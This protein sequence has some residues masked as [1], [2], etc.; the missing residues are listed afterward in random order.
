MIHMRHLSL[1]IGGLTLLLAGC[2]TDLSKTVDQTDAQVYKVI[3]NQW[4]DGVGPK[5]N[6]RIS[7]TVL[8]PV[9]MH[10]IDMSISETGILTLPQSVT[11]ATVNNRQYQTE[12][13]TLYLTA[14]D[15]SDIRH[16]YEP[17]P[18]LGSVGEFRKTDSKESRAIYGNTGFEQLLATGARVGSKISLGWVD[19]ISGDFRS[20]FSTVASGF[21]TQPLLRGAGRKVALENLTQAERNTLYQI[22]SFNRYRKEF[23]VSII[24]N[25]YLILKQYD[26]HYKAMDN[27]FALFET[28]EKLEKRAAAGRLPQ[29]ELE[30]ARQDT[31]SA[32]SEYSQTGIDYLLAL[33]EFKKTLA[34]PIDSEFQLDVHELESLRQS[35]TGEVNMT[36]SEAIEIA[37]DQRL[38]LANTTDQVADAERKVDIA[39]DAIRTEL[40]L[41]GIASTER[42]DSQ[43]IDKYYSLSLQLDLPVDRLFEKNNY[44]RALITLMQQQRAHQELAD[45]I[46]TE[47]RKSYQ[48][49]QEA[50]ER[51]YVEHA[52]RELAQKRTKNTLLLLKYNRASTRDA[53]DAR[54]DLLRA[55][56]AETDALVDYAVACLEFYRDT[57]IMKIKPDNMW[58]KSIP[59][60][61]HVTAAT[62]SKKPVMN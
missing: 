33:D 1:F 41:I 15:F 34:L 54:D 13:E 62:T 43:T 40:N 57:G 53:L 26:R 59:S 51:Y 56:N 4:A 2:T 14:L 47:V 5:T 31:L 49:I 52:A 42:L 23:V 25:Y 11:L 58:E 50:Y 61:L 38:D 27:Y 30:Q 22:R 21:I 17:M 55:Q 19:I 45:Q 20:G 48:Q 32:L 46:I 7:G 3:D 39:A 24:S 6:Y 60:E 37:L 18:F 29:H 36:E 12:K 8:E 28:Q 16:L 44:R 10:A 9:S 35:V